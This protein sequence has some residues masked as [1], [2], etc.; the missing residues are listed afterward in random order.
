VKGPFSLWT[1]EEK[2]G[3]RTNC[4]E[5]CKGCPQV[6]NDTALTSV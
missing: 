4:K 1:L 3:E 2:L 5:E 6:I